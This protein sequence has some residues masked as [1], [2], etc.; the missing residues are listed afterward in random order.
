MALENNKLI[1][2]AEGLQILSG[3]GGGDTSACVHIT[4]DETVGGVKTFSDSIV[5]VDASKVEYG[6]QSVTGE[7]YSMQQTYTYLTSN[8]SHTITFTSMVGEPKAYVLEAY[9]DSGIDS[10]ESV[11]FIAG[12]ANGDTGVFCDGNGNNYSTGF[13]HSYSNGSFTITAPNNAWFNISPGNSGLEY[14]LFYLLGPSPLTFRESSIVPGNGQTSVTYAGIESSYVC[15]SI[16]MLE[17]QVSFSQY[18]RVAGI[19]N[20]Y[21]NNNITYGQHFTTAF[22]NTGTYQ[23]SD[24]GDLTYSSNAYFHGGGTYKVHY[25]LI[26]DVDG[27]GGGGS[28]SSSFQNLAEELAT[29]YEK[30]ASGI[31]ANHFASGVIPTVPAISTNVVSD[32]TNNSN[33]TAPSAVYDELH[34]IYYDYYG[35]GSTFTIEPNVFLGL[36]GITGNTTLYFSS[37]IDNTVE[38][39][40]KFQL[41]ISSNIQTA[42][43]ITWPAQIT[44]WEGGTPPTIRIGKKYHVSVINGLAIVLEV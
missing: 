37:P 26:E 42:P 20:Y 12:D 39:E 13:T 23:K 25:L 3:G 36:I 32:R 22:Q 41:T 17:S 16:V 24:S 18:N 43:T 27:S 31:P 8:S 29:K 14:R 6:S 4:G 40:Y 35:Q 38:N 9:Y 44:A 11:I 15:F 10:I 5:V 19:F 1:T 2:Y 30:P 7:S 33:T 34:P 21:Y 28:S